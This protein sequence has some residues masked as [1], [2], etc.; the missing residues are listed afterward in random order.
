MLRQIQLDISDYDVRC[1][2]V[3]RHWGPFRIVNLQHQF[4]SLFRV[5]KRLFRRVARGRA[6]RVVRYD[7]LISSGVRNQD[8]GESLL[9]HIGPPH[10]T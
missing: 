6:F 8:D 4:Q 10:L 2:D 7:D 1:P 5:G 9:G 3:G